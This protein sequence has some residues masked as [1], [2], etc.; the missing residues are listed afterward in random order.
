MIYKVQ[1]TGTT[2]YIGFSFV[3]EPTSNT[4][5]IN[6]QPNYKYFVNSIFGLISPSPTI[7]VDFVSSNNDTLMI[8][9]SCCGSESFSIYGYDSTTNKA[10]TPFTG[11]T[12]N[13]F[14]P[15]NESIAFEIV[16]SSD[17]PNTY[18]TGCFEYIGTGETSATTIHPLQSV[19]AFPIN[20]LDKSDNV[21]ANF[22][23]TCSSCISKYPCIESLIYFKLCCED[24]TNPNNN[25][26]LTTSIGTFIPG[27]VYYVST[28]T[29]NC[30]AEVISS[31]TQTI[32]PIYDVPITYFQ[33]NG[34]IECLGSNQICFEEVGNEPEPF[35]TADT[36]CGVVYVLKNE[37]EPITIYPVGLDCFTTNISSYGLSDGTATLVISGGTPP[38]VISWSN[39]NF[40]N[41][42]INQY[43]YN[44]PPGTYQATVTDYYGDF[45]ETVDCVIPGITPPPPE[46]TP[47]P[48]P[49]PIVGDFCMTLKSSLI[50]FQTSVFVDGKPSYISDN[51]LY[52]ITWSDINQ[53]W[54]LNNYTSSFQVLNNNPVYPPITGWYYVG[55]GGQPIVVEGQ[56]FSTELCVFFSGVCGEEFITLTESYD[57]DGIQ[58]WI[59]DLPCSTP[60]DFLIYFN[61][62]TDKWETSGMTNVVGITVEAEIDG[63][64]IGIWDV[65]SN[66]FEFY[67]TDD[68]CGNTGVLKMSITKNNPINGSDGNIVINT[69]GGVSPYTYSIDGG[70][71]FKSVPIFNKLNPG[72]YPV[73]TKDASGQTVNSVIK[74]NNLPYKTIYNVSLSTSFV[75]ISST[76]TILTKEYYTNVTVSPPIPSGSTLTFDLVHTN[77]FETSPSYTSA[78]ITTSS[79]LTKNSSVV[80]ITSTSFATGET[81][82]TYITCTSYNIY[83]SANTENWNN[84][85][86][87]YGDVVLITTNTT[88]NKNE[89]VSCYLGQS[90]ESYS[91][92]NVNISG[93]SPCGILVT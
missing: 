7:V 73:Q 66:E 15:L 74:L 37:C 2:D 59:G 29:F 54:S 45:T 44:L 42:N 31:P 36:P 43:L 93:C 41:E 53:R 79:V 71:S 19:V 69:E 72:L 77:D 62:T 16:V 91:I 38:Y 1:N 46:P 83:S 32:Y 20:N 47:E 80:P 61:T 9:D 5:V 30:C 76:S 50:H 57:I 68:P 24:N 34:C 84:I 52:S 64:P 75:I 10:L 78:T 14:S 17:N 51:G 55:Q 35:Y 58:T 56:C 49:V 8:F 81:L 70:T 89:K 86:M 88:V 4:K 82:N 3:D 87:S 65:S 13:E 48:T 90:Q 27:E 11:L 63:S 85:T 39:T 33:Y 12:T 26:A 22:I 40:M 28:P 6:I 25:F 21:D 60:G 92:V 23:S 67:S 18:L